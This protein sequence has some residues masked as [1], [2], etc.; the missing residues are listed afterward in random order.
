MTYQSDFTLP[1]EIVEQI[2]ENGL[3]YLPELIRT[4]V[5][6]AMKVERQRH[7]KAEMYERSEERQGHANGYKDKTVKT[8]VG[9]ITFAVPQVREGGFY[10]EA[11][12]KGLR[13]ERALTLTLAEMYI[14]GVSTRK[15]AAILEQMCGSGI[16][17]SA[18]S[19]ATKLLD[20][21]VN[22]WLMSPLLEM[23]YLYLDAR[24]EKV[25]QDGQIRDAAVL[26]AVGVDLSGHR[27]VL[28]VSISLGE[29]EIHWRTFLESLLKRGLRGVKLITSDDHSGL[30]AARQAVF[31][32]IPWQRCQF[33]LQQNAQSYVPRKDMQKEVAED[34]RAIFTAP[35]RPRA[36][37][38]LKIA[39]EKYQKSA[40]KLA[41]WMES[42]IPE[43]LTI[44]SFPVAHRRLT[45]TTNGL[46]RLNREIKR[47]TRVV[48]IFPNEAAC[49]RLVGAILMETSDEWEGGKIYLNLEEG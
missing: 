8:R 2:A 5:N 45:R 43:G 36:E 49:L 10:P 34:I 24:Y 13:S 20:E 44:F 39:V 38:Y 33:H 40:S 12:E 47:R 4:V 46:E 7:L 22:Q 16:S 35:D 26:I 19:Q 30:K 18:V 1:P 32:G 29:Q 14:Q 17:S 6:T 23:P 42:N 48:S 15:V 27:K 3:D 28:G 41:N 31:G 11:L 9:E 21:K 25:R 37:E